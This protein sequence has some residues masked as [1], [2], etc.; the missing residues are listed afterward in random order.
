MSYSS[1]AFMIKNVSLINFAHNEHLKSNITTQKF[2][3]CSAGTP[4]MQGH[5]CLNTGVSTDE[6]DYCSCFNVIIYH[7]RYTQPPPDLWEWYEPYLEDEEVSCR[8]KYTWTTGL[9]DTYNVRCTCFSNQQDI[10]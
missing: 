2:C 1:F 10:L 3:P 8:H 6:R 5:F 9:F 7:S 4:A